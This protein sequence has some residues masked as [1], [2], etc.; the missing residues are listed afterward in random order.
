MGNETC[1]SFLKMNKVHLFLVAQHLLYVVLHSYSIQSFI[2][3]YPTQLTPMHLHTHT[4][5]GVVLTQTI[6]VTGFA[7]TV[8]IGTTIEIHFMA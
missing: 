7:K 2:V 6:N 4:E 3:L 5:L 8:P 1:V